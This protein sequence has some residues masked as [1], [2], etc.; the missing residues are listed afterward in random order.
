MTT[1]QESAGSAQIGWRVAAWAAITGI[2]PTTV[3]DYIRDGR[4][5]AKPLNDDPLQKSSF[6]ILTPPRE[7][8]ESLD[9]A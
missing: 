6:L 2:P 1:N 7:F 4:I 3:R 8:I 9:D 5:S